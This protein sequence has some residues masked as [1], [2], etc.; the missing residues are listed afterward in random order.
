VNIDLSQACCANLMNVQPGYTSVDKLFIK[1]LLDRALEQN[2][3]L[4]AGP[5][6]KT[7]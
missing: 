4:T 2:R 5:P 3:P 1:T 6:R 7:R